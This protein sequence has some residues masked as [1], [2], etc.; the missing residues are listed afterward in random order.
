MHLRRLSMQYN[1][2]E[3]KELA[4]HLGMQYSTWEGLYD[5]I[6]EEPERLNFE[7]LRKC[8]DQYTITFN[9]IR[10][11]VERG[12][13]QNPHSLCKVSCTVVKIFVTR[14]ISY[15]CAACFSK[16]YVIILQCL[17]HRVLSTI[18]T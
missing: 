4:I 15:L 1:V 14:S 13:I 3:T 6:G 16:V 18:H 11:A 9:D 17:I 10:K 8:V 7:T 5:T 12:N 2:H